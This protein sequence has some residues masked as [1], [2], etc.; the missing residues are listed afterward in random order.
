MKS[1]PQLTL[2]ELALLA[3]AASSNRR[4][5]NAMMFSSLTNTSPDYLHLLTRGFI[6]AARRS[7]KISRNSKMYRLAHLPVN[8]LENQLLEEAMAKRKRPGDPIFGKKRWLIENYLKAVELAGLPPHEWFLD[9]TLSWESSLPAQPEELPE[10]L[11]WNHLKD[12]L[13]INDQST[14]LPFALASNG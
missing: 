1:V 13:T 3:V 14:T 5:F 11:R 4:L 7:E 2:H 10:S 6:E 12:A 9:G 8:S